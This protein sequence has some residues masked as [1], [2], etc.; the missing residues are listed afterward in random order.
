MCYTDF[1]TQNARVLKL[2]KQ[3][4]FDEQETVQNRIEKATGY[5]D[6]LDLYT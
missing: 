5:D 3:G 6:Q 4:D 2:E 1:S